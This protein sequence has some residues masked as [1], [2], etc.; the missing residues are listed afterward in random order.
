MVDSS[1][2]GLIIRGI[3]SLNSSLQDLS[4]TFSRIASGL[5]INSAADD[6]AGLALATSFRMAAR[7]D[8]QA[9]RNIGD[10]QSALS[11][12]DGSVAQIQE[13]N[14]RRAELA[15]QAANG[16][17]SDEQRA[18]L[19][20]EFGQLGDEI[21]RIAETTEFNGTKLLNGELF[22]VQVGVSSASASS[23][24]AVSVGGLTIGNAYAASGPLDISSQTGAQVALGAVQQFSQTVSAQQANSLGA[25]QARLSSLADSVSV[26]R[27]E[28]IGAA[29]RIT[30]TDFATETV[31]RVIQE[32]RTRAS[33]AVL[34]QSKN[35]DASV[36]ALLSP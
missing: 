16:A 23:G 6:A 4:R 11:I 27:E 28:G 14:A 25:A 19:Q 13:I 34:S 17:Y 20:Q 21:Q 30:D 8:G 2:P 3:S 36:L 33:V 26:R 15:M 18:A 29:A 22:S 5:R 31:N 24:S 35:L 12:A 1:P 10:A 7:L 9:L 32:I